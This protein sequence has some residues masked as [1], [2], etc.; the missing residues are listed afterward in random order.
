MRADGEKDLGTGFRPSCWAWNSSSL[1]TKMLAKV[2]E[3]FFTPLNIHEALL[4]R[5][6]PTA[7][8]TAEPRVFYLR[9][10]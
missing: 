1:E 5:Q 8:P 2:M 3:F 10:G 4:H 9:T 6:E 7:G